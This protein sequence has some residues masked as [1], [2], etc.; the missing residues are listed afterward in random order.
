[1]RYY[2]WKF[3]LYN[4]RNYPTPEHDSLIMIHNDEY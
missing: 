1:M 4:D 2:K 3:G